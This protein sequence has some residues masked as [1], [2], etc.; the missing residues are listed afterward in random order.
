MTATRKQFLSWWRKQFRKDFALP[1]TLTP[2]DSCAAA[3]KGQNHRLRRQHMCSSVIAGV[4]KC[5]QPLWR[6]S[7]AEFDKLSRRKKSRRN[8]PEPSS[9]KASA[10][11]RRVH[12]RAVLSH[13]WRAESCAVHGC[14]GFARGPCRAST[15]GGQGSQGAGLCP[16]TPTADPAPTSAPASLGCA[17]HVERHVVEPDRAERLVE[18]PPPAD[19]RPVRTT[20]GKWLLSLSSSLSCSLQDR[21][22]A[23]LLNGV[24][25]GA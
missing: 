18:R 25:G 12:V 24:E 3:Q 4:L 5:F 1:D 8:L 6:T 17:S 11:F 15:T 19:E 20:S 10:P 21:S 9:A 2:Y 13:A 14:G 16:E 23:A 7:G 22:R